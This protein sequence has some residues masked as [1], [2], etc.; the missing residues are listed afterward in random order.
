MT[1]SRNNIECHLLECEE[2]ETADQD[3]TVCCAEAADLV[4][5]VYGLENMVFAVFDQPEFLRE[6]MDIIADWNRSRMKVV[7]DAGVDLY[8]KRVAGK[9]SVISSPCCRSANGIIVH[10]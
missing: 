7:L 9:K 2:S 3:L 5:W 1:S 10:R 6:L 4:G 8:I